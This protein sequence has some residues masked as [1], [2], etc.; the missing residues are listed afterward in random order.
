M[1]ARDQCG[2]QSLL[3]LEMSAIDGISYCFQEIDSVQ[4]AAYEKINQIANIKDGDCAAGESLDEKRV[5]LAKSVNVLLSKIPDLLAV[6]EVNIQQVSNADL[7]ALLLREKLAIYKEKLP[8][9]RRKFKESQLLAYSQEHVI[10]HDQR[11]QE[12]GKHDDPVSLG[13]KEDLFAGRTLK[14]DDEQDGKPI[15]DQILTQNKNITASLKL[16]KQLMTMSVMQ[17]E[18]NIETLDQQTKDMSSLNDKLI[19]LESVL[20]KSK[21]IVKFIEKQDRRDR[22]R[23]YIA[24][25]FLLLCSAWVAWRRILKTPVKILMWTLL[26]FFGVFNWV[27]SKRQKVNPWSEQRLPSTVEASNEFSILSE[28][29]T[30]SDN[31]AL[32]ETHS[33]YSAVNV[34]EPFVQDLT[35]G[36]AF[37][38]W[39]E[40]PYATEIAQTLDQDEIS[41]LEHDAESSLEYLTD[42]SSEAVIDLSHSESPSTH[43]TSKQDEQ[44]LEV[45]SE[46]ESTTNA[47]DGEGINFGDIIATDD[48]AETQ[49]SAA[50]QDS[51]TTQDSTATQDSATQESVVERLQEESSVQQPVQEFSELIDEVEHDHDNSIHTNEPIVS[52]EVP[53][54][55]ETPLVD[56]S[57]LDGG[58]ID[59]D[60]HDAPDV[61]LVAS[62]EDLNEEIEIPTEI[63]PTSSYEERSEV[64]V[65]GHD[66]L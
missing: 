8:N 12:Y 15:D 25:G 35:S 4:F 41:R 17:T 54:E 43:E 19:D 30:A 23:I 66:E 38:V 6:I 33:A 40:E 36:K 65:D 55:P 11:I 64:E 63:A 10:I 28:T 21:Q 13:T 31:P 18:L 42:P 51:T 59:G 9:L 32:V 48:S 26:K 47:D 1:L 46:R 37:E 20:L 3:D 16:T 45:T 57:S 58:S 7:D 24:L 22:T 49:D 39:D 27:A 14:K 56:T 34:D 53:S 50:T 5:A 2:D 52:V 60:E 44:T 62:D 29:A 61:V